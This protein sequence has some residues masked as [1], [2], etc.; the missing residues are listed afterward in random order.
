MALGYV[1]KNHPLL[2]MFTCYY[3]SSKVRSLIEEVKTKENEK[4]SCRAHYESQSEELK[5]TIHTLQMEM[6]V[7]VRSFYFYYYNLSNL[8]I[9]CGQAIRH[10]WP[11][12]PR[13]NKCIVW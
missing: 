12:A 10:G 13:L 11:L 8:Y 2:I 9:I 4:K 3:S 1:L 7:K 6:K 5:S